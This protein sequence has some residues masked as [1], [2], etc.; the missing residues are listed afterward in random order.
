MMT[1]LAFGYKFFSTAYAIDSEIMINQVTRFRRNWTSLGRYFLYLMSKVF[2]FSLDFNPSFLSLWTY[3]LLILSNLLILYLFFLQGIKNRPA[4]FAFSA[5]YLS[6]P[7]IIEQT[8][9]TMQSA[10]VLLSTCFIVI[11]LILISFFSNSANGKRYWYLVVAAILDIIAFGTYSSLFVLFIVLTLMILV[12]R[13]S[14]TNDRIGFQRYLGQVI[15]FLTIFIFSYVTNVLLVSIS[16]RVIGVNQSSQYFNSK[17]GIR[18][19]GFVDYIQTLKNSFISNFLTL[20]NKYFFWVLLAGFLLGVIMTLIHHKVNWLLQIVTLG[21]AFVFSLTSLIM[22]GNVVPIR[23]LFPAVPVTAAF[24]MLFITANIERKEF[25]R[26]V[27]AGIAIISFCQAKVTSDLCYSSELI[28][29][30]DLNRTQQL[31]SK[32]SNQGLTS[33]NQYQLAVIGNYHETDPQVLKGDVVGFSFYEWDHETL[34][35]SSRR[36]SGLWQSLGYQ[37]R[38]ISK[39]DY[40]KLKHD[41]EQNPKPQAVF[42]YNNII[43]INLDYIAN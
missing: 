35:N 22:L 29:R 15:P 2:R 41:L 25:L 34:R 6:S 19:L 4:M 8:I 32:L 37:V 28:Y 20:H 26:I 27:I 30:D 42:V 12:I 16:K 13:L 7:I 31:V 39:E 11:S 18:T 3:L 14:R 40:V 36:V 17:I 1:I 10:E 9:F 5:I 43:V 33:V 21:F 24:F 38:T 23:V